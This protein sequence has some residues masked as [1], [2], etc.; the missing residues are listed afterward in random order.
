MDEKKQTY[1]KIAAGKRIR[2]CRKK[3]GFSRKKIAEKLGKTEKYYGDIER[4]YC[5][6]SVETMTNIANCLGISLDYLVLG[7]EDG[8]ELPE[9][10]RRLFLYL[11]KCDEK[12]RKKALELL[13]VYLSEQYASNSCLKHIN[14]NSYR[15]GSS[16]NNK[17]EYAESDSL[18]QDF[19]FIIGY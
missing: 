14:G 4:G 19:L 17:F 8:Q 18:L 9:D 3:L 12:K 1:D 11:Q 10:M 2:E 7:E 5:G 13:K 15:E 16:V 6:M